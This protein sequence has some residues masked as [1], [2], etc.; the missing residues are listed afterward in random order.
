MKL[1]IFAL[2]FIF[3][4]NTLIVKSPAFSNEHF[5]PSKYTCDG[6]NINPEIDLENIPKS[7][8]SLAIIMDDPDSPNGEF[9]HWVMWNIPVTEKIEEKTITGSCGKNS[10][11]EN[12]Y[13][14]P[15]PPNGLHHYHFNVYA[16]DQKL[17]LH[18]SSGKKELL[19]AMQGHILAS[20]LLTGLYKS[21]GIGK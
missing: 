8:Q 20:G 19:S 1:F 11:K 15:C 21:P 14:G 12:K 16:L 5:I 18:D 2:T 7:T 17:N 13:Y 4:N 6:S 9:V 3:M 10:R